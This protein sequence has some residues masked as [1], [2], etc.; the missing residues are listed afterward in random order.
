MSKH[1]NQEVWNVLERLVESQ[2]VRDNSQEFREDEF[3]K[4]I[5]NLPKNVPKIENG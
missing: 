3:F 1:K 5:I 2:D 4:A